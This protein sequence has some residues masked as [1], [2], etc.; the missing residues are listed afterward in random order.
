MCGTI[1]GAFIHTPNPPLVLLHSGRPRLARKDAMHHWDLWDFVVVFV[2]MVL[3]DRKSE[4]SLP[5]KTNRSHPLSTFSCF[6]TN[7]NVSTKWVSK[8]PYTRGVS[9]A[10]VALQRRR[11]LLKP[12]DTGDRYLL[13]V[14]LSPYSAP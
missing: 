4:P 11:L 7:L 9:L 10:P 5:R 14:V 13:I 12:G 2:F 6:W 8:K 3:L 1:C